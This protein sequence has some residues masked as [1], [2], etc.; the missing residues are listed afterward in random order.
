M[1]IQPANNSPNLKQAASK[2]TASVGCPG[3]G[4]TPCGCGKQAPSGNEATQKESVSISAQ[5]APPKDKTP[6]QDPPKNG[7]PAPE[8]VKVAVYAQDPF[9]DKP[10]VID[11]NKSDIG[12]NLRS[13]R[14]KIRD[15]R[16]H[17]SPDGQG[18]FILPEGSDGLSQVNALV[19]TDKTLD[20]FE[21]YRGSEIPW[22][23]RGDQISV[24]PHKQEGRNAYYSRWG[25]GT[26][27]FYSESPGLGTVM[28]TANSTDV[29]SHETGHAMLDGLRPGFFGTHDAETGAFHEAFGDCAAM[30]LSLSD[31]SNRARTYEATGGNLLDNHNATSSLAEE[32]GAARAFDNDD[33]SDDHKTYLRTALTDFV[34][35]DPATLPPG[36]G[37]DT[38][39]GREVHSFA[40]LFA[41][42]F[43]D[44][45]DSVYM[46][47]I[48]EDRQC[49]EEALGT[50]QAV[51]G[52]LLLRSVDAGPTNGTT[53]KQ[54]AL[55]IL[56]ADKE[57][58]EG[59]YSEGLTKVFLKRKLIT[60]EDIAADE[61]RRADVPKIELPANLSKANA[62][63]F[64]E[65]NAETL[66]VSKDLPFV[67]DSVSKNGRGETFV[68]FRYA[69]EV[70]VTVDGLEGMTTDVHG[71]LNLVFNAEGKLIDRVESKITE[72]TIER[73]MAGIADS[74]AKN[75][76]AEDQGEGLFKSDA[77]G[78]NLFKSAI[79]GSKIVRVPVSGCAIDGGHDHSH[80]GHHHG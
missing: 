78:T 69:Q 45:I 49:P 19:M 38:E 46:Q 76:I 24:T 36:R 34:Y 14:V 40:R 47:S 61:Q 23:T 25:G 71:G 20:L 35:Q 56:A 68:S 27:Y 13:E 31:A 39:L 28:K 64:L 48:Y 3:C 67:P 1:S 58:N 66:G 60:P 2:K 6:P 22:A 55:G 72:D 33:P 51:M 21:D 41:S 57:T 42:A 50:S 79:Q 5:P 63:N 17:A 62:V 53:F 37:S 52:P 10:M 74:K 54:V 7:P 18:N 73:E 9:V 12:T 4:A 11:I 15:R 8:T 77:P 26:N 59:K 44:A 65:D 30:L 32:F 80:E 16:E 75:A 29:V 43:Y 70:P